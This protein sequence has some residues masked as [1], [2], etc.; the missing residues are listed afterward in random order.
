MLKIE[1]SNT[2]PK[3][4]FES[5]DYVNHRSPSENEHLPDGILQLNSI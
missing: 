3:D 5:S 1:Y 2:T 4:I